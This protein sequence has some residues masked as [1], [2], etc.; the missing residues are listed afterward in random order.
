[1]SNDDEVIIEKGVPVPKY[2]SVKWPWEKMH[3]GDSFVVTTDGT[4][5]GSKAGTIRHSASS[6]GYKIAIRMQDETHIRVWMIGKLG[7]SK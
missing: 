4:R 6:R 5:Q 1:M 7:E 3:P 2:F